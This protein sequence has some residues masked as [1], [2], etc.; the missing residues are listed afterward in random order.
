MSALDLTCA[1]MSDLIGD[2]LD[3]ALGTIEYTTFEMHLMYCS[4]CRTYL[5]QMRETLRRLA[6]LRNDDIDP[7]EREY[8]LDAFRRARR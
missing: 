4:D 3:K 8:L 5:R 7:R 6:G 1:T 2:Y